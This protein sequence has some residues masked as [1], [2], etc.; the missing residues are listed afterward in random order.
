MMRDAYDFPN[1]RVTRYSYYEN[2]PN[3]LDGD[4]LSIASPNQV[5]AGAPDS[6]EGPPKGGWRPPPATRTLGRD[7]PGLPG[8]RMFGNR[9][10]RG[11]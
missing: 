2:Q 9:E 4:L 3:A 10:G 1:G 8:A 6:P 7:A 5:A 11:A